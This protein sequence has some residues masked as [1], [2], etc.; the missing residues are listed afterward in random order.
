[1]P[2]RQPWISKHA[3]HYQKVI[4]A[5]V[6][7]RH[8]YKPYWITIP[9]RNSLRCILA[10]SQPG[11]EFQSQSHNSK[12]KGHTGIFVFKRHIYKPYWITIPKRISLIYILSD[13]QPG[14]EFQSQSHNSRSKG[15]TVNFF[16]KAHLQAI[17][18]H[19][20]KKNFPKMYPCWPKPRKKNSK[21]K[22]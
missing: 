10:D 8:I 20:T 2:P 9:K 18:N 7:K 11:N 1:M 16:Q 21:S 13:L 5:F 4:W 17:L 22:S 19:Y 14:N 12:S 6:F 3:N 15:H